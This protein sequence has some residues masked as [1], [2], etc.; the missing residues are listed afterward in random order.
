MASSFKSHSYSLITRYCYTTYNTQQDY[1]I[2]VQLKHSERQVLPKVIS[3]EP[4]HKVPIIQWD[5][6]SSTP[7]VLLPLRRWPPHLIH[8]YLD[9][10]H[11]PSQRHPDPLSRFATIH[12]AYA[13]LIEIDAANNNTTRLTFYVLLDAKWNISETPSRSIS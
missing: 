1:N 7:K 12:F 9:R 3:K 11:S 4:R 8:S 13:R 6:P 10:P 5:V 2:K